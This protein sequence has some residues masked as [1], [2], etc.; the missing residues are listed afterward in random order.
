[1]RNAFSFE[2]TS[3]Y[4]PSNSVT[5]TSTI[6]KPASTPA[7]SVSFSPFST[8]G[9]YSRGTEPPLTASMNSKPFPASFGSSLSQTCPYWPRPPDCLMNLPSTSGQGRLIVSR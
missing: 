8:A 1:M 5:F 6:G 4:D 2:S 7:G 3:W 9:M